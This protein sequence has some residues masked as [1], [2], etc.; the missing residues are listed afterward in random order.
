MNDFTILL[1]P[2][3]FA[4]SVSATL[5]LL[6][7]AVTMAPSVGAATPKWKV[8]SLCEE[9]PT[10][11]SNGMFIDA[12]P[13]PGRVKGD[14]SIWVIPGLATRSP[15]AVDLRLEQA[16]AQRGIAALKT[17]A[18][19]GGTVAA[20]CS[21][22]FLLQAAG[23]LKNRKVT[24][25][26]WLASHLQKVEPECVVDANRLV[27]SDGTVWTA[28]AAFAQTDL[29]LRLIQ[30]RFGNALA[31]AVSR[32]LVIDGREAQAPF[33]VP[34]MLANGNELIA[35][36]SQ[37]IEK[38]L[39][40]ALSVKE[41]AEKLCISEKTLARRIK[42]ATGKNPSELIQFVRLKRA[43]RLLETTSMSVDQVAEK[44]GYSDSTALRRL[45]RKVFNATPRQ[46]RLL[47][48]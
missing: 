12:K 5:D 4:S 24:T 6:A 40:N 28:G 23:L 45:M 10:P 29:M 36:L 14:N 38:S 1:V 19:A 8:L 46:F 18:R 2:G 25:T 15:R 32:V 26:W 48:S 7:A 35:N 37:Q 44:V 43:R 11:L 47:N 22:V 17:H 30:A 39:P 31:E 9:G 21:G 42:A 20:S 41:M 34:A 3:A 13:L 33:I 27:I 16:D